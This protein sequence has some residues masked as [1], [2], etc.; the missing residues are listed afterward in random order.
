VG[1]PRL[2][3]AV[4]RGTSMQP[5]LKPGDRLLIRYGAA[6]RPG[7]LVVARLPARPFG[8]KRVRARV[9]GGWD[10][11]SDHATEGTDSRV[12]GPVPDD[13]VFAVVMCRLWPPRPL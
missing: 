11:R 1:L 10:L 8:V 9:D 4:V 12:F 6:P 5:T 2:G 13:D 7:C 3:M